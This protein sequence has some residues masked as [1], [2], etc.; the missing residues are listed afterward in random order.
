MSAMIV[1]STVLTA[2][3][4]G[5]SPSVCEGSP[6]LCVDEQGTLIR[7]GKPFKGSGVNYFNAF[8]RTLSDPG[9]SSYQYG[10]EMLGKYGIPF[11]RFMAGG[12]WP[13]DY[14]LYFE[15]KEKYF[16][17]LDDVVKAAQESGV[18]LIPSLFWYHSALPDMVK[19]PRNA[20]GDPNSK[21]TALMRE[22]IREMVTR[23]KDSPAIWG[24][25]FGNEYN[26]EIDLPNAADNRPPVVPELGTAGSRSEQDDL[27]GDMVNRALSMFA[28]EVRKY[29]KQRIIISGNSIPRPSAWNQKENHT[30]NQDTEEQF[31]EALLGENPDPLNILSVHYYLWGEKRFGQGEDADAALS[32]MQE[33]ARKAKKPL[34]VGEF[35]IGEAVEDGGV[36]DHELARQRFEDLLASLAKADIPLSALWVYD[37]WGQKDWNVTGDNERS[38]QLQALQ[39][40]NERLK[41]G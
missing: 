1:L 25:E 6:G 9:D 3:S 32:L 35:G 27:T 24:W 26:L 18:G 17:L 10:L 5:G 37:Y 39:E 29:D 41:K 20:W 19:E 34:F 23:Y 13:N 8:A 28:E 30:F 22:Y 14:K 2:C 21:T 7:E 16:S 33:I 12:Y 40:W 4:D 38:Y 11:A 31:A 36:T 15:D